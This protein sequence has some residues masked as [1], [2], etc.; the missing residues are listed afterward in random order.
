MLTGEFELA[1]SSGAPTPAS[2]IRGR[3]W[4]IFDLFSF[5]REGLWNKANN[6]LGELQ[7]AKQDEM[8]ILPKPEGNP[9]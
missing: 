1:R 4:V 2:V 7:G 3:A 5:D 9:P 8:V 6:Y